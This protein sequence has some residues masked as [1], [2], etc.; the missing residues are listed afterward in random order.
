MGRG[1]GNP[2]RESAKSLQQTRPGPILR[3]QLQQRP[4]AVLSHQRL[5]RCCQLPRFVRWRPKPEGAVPSSPAR[6]LLQRLLPCSIYSTTVYLAQEIKLTLRQGHLDP[7]SRILT[8]WLESKAASH[9]PGLS[10]NW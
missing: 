4:V 8:E 7:D 3:R 10:H 6:A 1:T 5:R 2:L 9:Y